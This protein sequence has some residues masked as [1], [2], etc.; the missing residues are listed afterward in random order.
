MTTGRI[1]QISIVLFCFLIRNEIVSCIVCKVG[2]FHFSFTFV[3]FSFGKATHKLPKGSSRAALFS[4]DLFFGFL[5]VL[6]KLQLSGAALH[7]TKPFNRRQSTLKK[8]F[9]SG[10]LFLRMVLLGMS[11]QHN[12]RRLARKHRVPQSNRPSTQKPRDFLCGKR[13][14]AQL[15]NSIPHTQSRGRYQASIAASPLSLQT[16]GTRLLVHAHGSRPAFSQARLHVAHVA[17]TSTA[18]AQHFDFPSERRLPQHPT[19]GVQC[20]GD[21]RRCSQ[22]PTWSTPRGPHFH[23]S[24]P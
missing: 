17:G 22:T 14:P 21:P 3:F 12:K 9:S 15:L 13:Y 7:S 1:N 16:H 6:N 19:W 20:P 4:V 11:T 5:N 8:K 23:W 2:T 10:S 18:S 24:P